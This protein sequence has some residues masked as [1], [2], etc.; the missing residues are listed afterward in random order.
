MLSYRHA[1]HAGNHA[2]VLKHL[3]LLQLIDHLRQKDKPFTAIDTHAGAGLYALDAGAALQLAEHAG[4]VSRLLAAPEP[5]PAVATYLQ[6]VRALNRP[7]K[8]EKVSAYPGSPWLLKEGLRQADRLHLFELHP[9]EIKVLADNFRENRRQV[10]VHHADGFAGLKALL[11]PPSRRGLVIIDPSYETSADY[12]SV[13]TALS[14]A[15]RRFATGVYA[16][17][18][19]EIGRKEARQ[20]PERLRQIARQAGRDWLD[21]TLSV[22]RQPAGSF[23]MS[24]SG[25]FIVN[26]P[27]TLAATLATTLPWLAAALAENA[28]AGFTLTSSESDEKHDSHDE[29]RPNRPPPERS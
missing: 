13:G 11:P 25:V 20:L 8:V 12:R 2:D 27:W 29:K 15:L 1:F 23:G 24:G 18:Y 16:I 10:T 26:P 14:E 19:P 4:G 3:V 22:R 28:G 7:E 9:N 21:A 5:P 17:W 6:A